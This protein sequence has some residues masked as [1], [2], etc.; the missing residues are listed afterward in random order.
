MLDRLMVPWEPL[1]GARLVRVD[2]RL[3]VRVLD[4]EAL[5][6]GL[7]GIGHHLG[8]DMVGV[9]V[10]DANHGRLPHRA[11]AGVGQLGTSRVAHVL[12]LAAHV[13][14]IGLDRPLERNPVARLRHP[15]FADAMEHE[16][17]GLL[18]DLEVSVQFHGRDGLEAGEAQVDG[19]GPLAKRNV[20]ARERGARL[21]REVTSAVRTPVRHRLVAGLAGARTAALPAAS[22][23]RPDHGLDPFPCR[24]FAREHVHDF[25][26]AEPVAVSLSGCLVCH[27]SL[28]VDDGERLPETNGN[29]NDWL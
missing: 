5:E 11:P 25:D 7:G 9:A 24:V 14:L 2:L 6:G 17:S 10:L 20:R 1:V 3:G 23:V 16:P 19:Y 15:R 4:H 22:T 12:A 29:A 21:D 26:E 13:R 18:A 8:G 27:R 28:S